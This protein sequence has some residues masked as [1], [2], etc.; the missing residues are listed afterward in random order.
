M[1]LSLRIGTERPHTGVR[2]PTLRSGLE[3]R[4]RRLEVTL[5]IRAHTLRSGF[6][7]NMR[8]YFEVRVKVE[9]TITR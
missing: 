9:I 2:S 7:V 8:S 3:V 4:G 5:G 1:G 6:W